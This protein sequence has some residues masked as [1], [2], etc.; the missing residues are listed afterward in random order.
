MSAPLGKK[1]G[2]SP[3]LKPVDPTEVRVNC[4]RGEE[5][6]VSVSGFLALE[7]ASPPRTDP[8]RGRGGGGRCSG[9]G[10]RVQERQ[11]P[12]G[13]IEA[14][15][16][17]QKQDSGCGQVLDNL[18]SGPACSSFVSPS[19]PL[20]ASVPG[21]AT[22]PRGSLGGSQ[23]PGTGTGSQP[24]GWGPRGWLPWV[25]G[26]SAPCSLQHC[27]CRATVRFGGAGTTPWPQTLK[28]AG[29]GHWGLR[30]SAAGRGPG[31]GPPSVLVHPIWFAQTPFTP[32]GGPVTELEVREVREGGVFSPAATRLLACGPH[33]RQRIRSGVRAPLGAPWARAV[34][35]DWAWPGGGEARPFPPEDSPAL[36][37]GW[38]CPPQSQPARPAFQALSS[39]PW[40]LALSQTPPSTCCRGAAGASLRRRPPGRG[41]DGSPFQVWGQCCPTVSFQKILKPRPRPQESQ[42]SEEVGCGLAGWVAP[43][44]GVPLHR[45]LRLLSLLVQRDGSGP[46][47]PPALFHLPPSHGTPGRGRAGALARVPRSQSRPA[48]G[49]STRGSWA[50]RALQPPGSLP[51]ATLGPPRP[52]CHVSR[53]GCPPGAA[54][55]T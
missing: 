30:C 10:E 36:A 31:S 1:G 41:E 6:L 22:R 8:D 37:L 43:V 16:V 23:R 14:S 32:S 11:G 51:T 48:A 47:A 7:R 42:A 4:Q 40:S 12:G 15:M 2:W 18:T 24:G 27:L 50:H 44:R 46:G 45:G 20:G 29:G 38:P 28:A 55:G 17:S 52:Q 34:S 9:V 53:A 49:E 25:P 39:C 26:A 35:G 13:L 54:S 19:S 21:T 33:R 5:L 3:T